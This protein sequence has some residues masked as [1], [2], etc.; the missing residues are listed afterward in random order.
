MPPWARVREPPESGGYSCL[1]IG[2]IPRVRKAARMTRITAPGA[3][4]WTGL[5]WNKCVILVPTRRESVGK[6][7]KVRKSVQIVT[8]A[9]FY[10]ELRLFTTFVT[11]CHSGLPGLVF[12]PGYSGPEGGVPLDSSFSRVRF[13]SRKWLSWLFAGGLCA[14]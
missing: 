3:L 12:W 9:D 1:R 4:S 7:T 6:V 8:F 2:L 13:W 10:A 11:L 5:F 14:K